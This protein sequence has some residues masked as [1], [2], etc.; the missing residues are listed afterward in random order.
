[1]SEDLGSKVLLD[2]SPCYFEHQRIWPVH[3]VGSVG[4]AGPAC[5]GRTSR[6]LAPQKAGYQSGGKPGKARRD[7][8][9]VHY[10]LPKSSKPLPFPLLFFINLSPLRA[11]LEIF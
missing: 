9:K 7:S 10:F 5:N 4:T 8:A 3:T 2:P 1:V 11:G 6:K